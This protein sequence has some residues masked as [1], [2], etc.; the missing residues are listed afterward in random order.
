MQTLLMLD[1]SVTVKVRESTRTA[2]A[3][4]EISVGVEASHLISV[5]VLRAPIV[6]CESASSQVAQPTTAMTQSLASR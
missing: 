4:E 6:L 3:R 5:H 2:F 1:E